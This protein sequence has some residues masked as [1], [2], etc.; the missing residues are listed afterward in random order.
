MGDL[1]QGMSYTADAPDNVSSKSER[2]KAAE[3]VKH[4]AEVV[5]ETARA[6]Y[7]WETKLRERRGKFVR[8]G[9]EGS[10]RFGGL[11]LEQF[12]GC[13]EHGLWVN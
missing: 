7:P 10:Q 1:D 6:E 4:P 2:F 13:L 8:L 9:H 5:R 12:S 3:S 11:F